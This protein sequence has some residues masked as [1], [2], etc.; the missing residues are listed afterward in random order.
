MSVV[1]VA[2]HSA[3]CQCCVLL[4][5]LF[6]VLLLQSKQCMLSVLCFVGTVVSSVVVAEQTHDPT[7]HAYQNK[8]ETLREE[9]R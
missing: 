7:N 3:C 9:H 8:I 1:V 4:V 6:R 2:E 5:Q